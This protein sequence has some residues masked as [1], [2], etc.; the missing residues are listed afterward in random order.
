MEE[1]MEERRRGEDGKEFKAVRRGWCLGTSEFRRE[2]LEQMA[3]AMGEHHNGEER[4][5]AA[6]ATAERIVTEEMK[7]RGW[8]DQD[9]GNRPKGDPGKVATA[10]RLRRETTMTLQW[11]AR[12]VGMGSASMVS[13]CLRFR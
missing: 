3:G 13:H 12:R 8:S 1:A 6:E 9:L 5:E 2:L 4:W 11:I 7:Q 10:R